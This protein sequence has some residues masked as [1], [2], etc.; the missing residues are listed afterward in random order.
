MAKDDFIHV[1][2]GKDYEK[3]THIN[4][5]QTTFCANRFEIIVKP[6]AEVH[7]DHAVQALR[8]WIRRCNAQ[9]MQVSGD[10]PS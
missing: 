6:N 10:M 4:G 7:E 5:V 1:T 2:T 8:D 3:I 9:V